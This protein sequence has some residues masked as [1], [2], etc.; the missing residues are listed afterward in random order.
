[1]DDEEEMALIKSILIII[2]YNGLHPQRANVMMRKMNFS[3][4]SKTATD[5]ESSPS[6][7]DLS[8]ENTHSNY[9][10]PADP[11]LNGSAKLAGA[12]LL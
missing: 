8:S 6:Q 4:E 9:R 12:L 11:V 7:H 1:M 10:I 5:Q 2:N 3:Q